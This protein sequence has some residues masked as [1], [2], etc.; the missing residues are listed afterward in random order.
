MF[1]MMS[2]GRAHMAR[3]ILV[4]GAVLALALTA[5]GASA[6]RARAPV[7]LIFWQWV[8]GCDNAVALYNKMHPNVKIIMRNVGASDSGLYP[9]LTTAIEVGAGAPDLAQI[10]FM[11]L[12]QYEG[13]GGLLD[14][15]KYGANAAK[16]QFVSWT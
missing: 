12:P 11:L 1:P 6:Q 3:K 15:G 10:E 16:S 4:G 5:P 7:T 9:K 13:T 2:E 8:N 14:M